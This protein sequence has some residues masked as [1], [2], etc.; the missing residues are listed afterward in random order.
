MSAHSGGRATLGEAPRRPRGRPP[1]SG[2]GQ[3]AATRERIID[4]AVELFAAK[5]FHATSVAEIGARADVQPGALYYHIHSKEE[6]LWEILRRYTEQALQGADAITTADIGPVDKLRELIGFHVRIIAEHRRAV[7]IQVRDGGALTGHRAAELQILRD[8][9]QDCW[10]Q[11]LVDGYR[12]GRLRS[13]D[14]AVVNGLLGMVNMLY[15]WYRPEKG[16]TAE[17]IAD[18]YCA[19]VL[20]GLVGGPGS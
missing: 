15:L 1:G 6:L 12:V 19:M 2:A 3:G 13:A 5:G 4:S 9:V 10:Q 16:D 7:T 11:V 8:K 17:S 18:Q 20:D 14:R